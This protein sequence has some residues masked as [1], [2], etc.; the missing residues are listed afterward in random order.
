MFEN[1]E[2]QDPLTLNLSVSEGDQT[3][4]GHG[5]KKAPVSP[6]YNCETPEIQVIIKEEEEGWTM[7]T[8][9]KRREMT[10]PHSFVIPTSKHM[11]R[12]VLFHMD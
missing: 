12:R 2:L 1:P 4:S 11:R 5:P 3:S 9:Q 6:D 7:R 8:S 10:L